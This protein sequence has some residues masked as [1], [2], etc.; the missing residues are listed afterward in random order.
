MPGSMV[1]ASPLCVV[2]SI[3]T[4]SPMFSWSPANRDLRAPASSNT[5]ST[6]SRC[7]SRAARRSRFSWRLGLRLSCGKW[8]KVQF[9]PFWQR[10]FGK[11][12]Q[13]LHVPWACSADP[14]EGSGPKLSTAPGVQGLSASA[15]PA[16][17][18]LVTSAPSFS[19]SLP[20]SLVLLSL[21]AASCSSS[22]SSLVSSLISIM[23]RTSLRNIGFRAPAG[24]APL[25]APPEVGALLTRPTARGTGGAGRS[26]G[27]SGLIASLLP[28]LLLFMMFVMLVSSPS[29]V[30]LGW[31]EMGLVIFS[32][33]AG[34]CGTRAAGT[35]SGALAERVPAGPPPGRCSPALTG[36]AGVDK[37]ARGGGASRPRRPTFPTRRLRS[38]TQS[39]ISPELF[40][41]GAPFQGQR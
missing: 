5:P 15:A 31:S 27:R 1:Y 12:L 26:R 35:N 16:S 20:S 28:L 3:A 2:S 8:Q 39:S 7:N 17:E 6:P 33:T 23:E 38:S 18:G 36:L 32:A 37:S 40:C 29:G 22:P 21:G 34:S 41:K 4:D 13:R 25:S 30:L 19:S 9:A 11:K 10:P 24:E 14:S